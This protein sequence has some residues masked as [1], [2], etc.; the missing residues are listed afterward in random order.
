MS[1]EAFKPVDRDWLKNEAFKVALDQKFI[2]SASKIF[3]SLD[4][5]VV[6]FVE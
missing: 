3:V 5:S 6:N 1:S 2:N 4:G